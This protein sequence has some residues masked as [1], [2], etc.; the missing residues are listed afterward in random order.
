MAQPENTQIDAARTPAMP[1]TPRQQA[2]LRMIVHEYVQ[3]GRPVGSRT[4][5]ERYPLGFSSATVRNEM[6]E[7]ELGGYVQHLHTSGGRIPTDVGYRF[8]V[9]HLM[10][11][12]ELPPG[13]Q[14]MIRH[15]FRQAEEHLDGWMELA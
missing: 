2:I 10:G 3:T 1:L 8:Y 5:I 4:L 11:D 9:D 7:L 6:A 13:E 12:V 15:Q 14:I